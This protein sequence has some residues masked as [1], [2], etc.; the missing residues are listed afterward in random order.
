MLGNPPS[1]P[2]F[3]VVGS[4]LIFLILPGP[5]FSSPFF[6]SLSLSWHFQ[7][8]V[9]THNFLLWWYFFLGCATRQP[10][11]T[12]FCLI[13]ENT[14]NGGEGGNLSIYKFFKRRETWLSNFWHVFSSFSLSCFIW[15]TSRVNARH[16][17]FYFRDTIFMCA[18]GTIF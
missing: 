11:F 7:K 13:K 8:N 4:S 17:L 6:V 16:H 18:Y 1:S 9:F 5:R 10:I 12:V 14:G 2:V 15:F 3:F